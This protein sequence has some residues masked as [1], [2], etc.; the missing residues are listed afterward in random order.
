MGRREE[1]AEATLGALG[2]KWLTGLGF[3]T[4]STHYFI[5]VPEGEIRDGD[6]GVLN[7]YVTEGLIG[8]L[9]LYVPLMV[10]LLVLMAFPSWGGFAVS[11]RDEGGTS[12]EQSGE[13]SW[14]IL[15][16]GIWLAATLASSITLGGLASRDGC[17]V[18]GYV[19][20]LT[21]AVLVTTPPTGAFSPWTRSGD[22]A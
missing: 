22:S 1:K 17:A 10:L 18:S 4:P 5:G 9:V 21:L 19:I 8:V 15:G 7:I 20:G 11:R 12:R 16:A 6:L 2:G 14:L 13:A 3:W